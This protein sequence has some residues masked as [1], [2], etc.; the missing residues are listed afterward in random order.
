MDTLASLG[1]MLNMQKSLVIPTQII[2]HLFF[3]LNSVTMVVK[4]PENKVNKVVDQC[5]W[6]LNADKTSIRS[7]AKLIGLLVSSF[8]AVFCGQMHYMSL[9]RYK[10]AALQSNGNFDS[11]TC[12]SVAAKSEVIWWSENIQQE[13]GRSIATH[14]PDMV[15][16]SDASLDGWGAVCQDN[17]VN[18]RWSVSE[19]EH[20]IHYLELLAIFLA[21]KCFCCNT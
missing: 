15:I 19:S 6:T 18:G 7:I 21:L 1:F 14:K 9:E 17:S 8:P 10:T 20:Q 3:W 4:L 11:Y 12:L 2:I 16:E 13:N 5:K